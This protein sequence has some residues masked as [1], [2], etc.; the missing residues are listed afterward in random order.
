MNLKEGVRFYREL[1][2]TRIRVNSDELQVLKE[3]SL[4]NGQRHLLNGQRQWPVDSNQVLIGN[5]KQRQEWKEALNP[6]LHPDKNLP[7]DEGRVW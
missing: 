1:G 7:G 6:E 3:A 5:E 2:M 4:L